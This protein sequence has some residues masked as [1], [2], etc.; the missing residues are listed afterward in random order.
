MIVSALVA[1][2]PFRFAKGSH[3]SALRR[4]AAVAAAGL[5][6]W[7]AVL[8]SSAVSARNHPPS[9]E[10]KT[11]AWTYRGSVDGFGGGPQSVGFVPSCDID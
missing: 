2:T 9:V 7:L 10:I 6:V 3:L 4:A 8:G 11:P 1:T 5:A